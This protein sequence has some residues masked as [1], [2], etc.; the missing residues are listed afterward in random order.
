MLFTF[1]NS[2]WEGSAHDNAILVD[3][4][5]RADLH[6]PHP[7]HGECHQITHCTVLNV[8]FCVHI[9]DRAL[10]TLFTCR[11]VLFIDVGFL[12]MPGFLASFRYQRY[13]LQEFHG[14][15]YSG[16]KELFNYRHSSLRNVIEQTF[17]V[18]KKRLPILR[19]MSNYK[20]IRQGPLVI[21]CCVVHNW[22]RLHA[23]TDPF[24]KK[25]DN[26]MAAEAV[27]DGFV[28]GQADYVD[29]SQHGL[30]YQSN[31]RDAIAT[32]MWQNHVGH[33]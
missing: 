13:H 3:S 26:E 5:T 32:A 21:A 29:M 7:P 1:I 18:L 22:I 20:S 28:R 6:F 15:Y 11:Q 25:A 14:C 16:P 2:G 31:F 12:N 9:F 24:F 8:D 17:G 30:A 19:S 4:I 10:P 23:A 33:G 27:A